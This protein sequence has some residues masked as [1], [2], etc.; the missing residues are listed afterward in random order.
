MT[1]N[2]DAASSHSSSRERERDLCE[3]SVWMGRAA[4]G[5]RDRDDVEETFPAGG[6]NLGANSSRHLGHK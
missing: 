3:E 4:N 1:R 5:E 2:R 6:E